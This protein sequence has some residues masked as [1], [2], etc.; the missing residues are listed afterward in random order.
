MKMNGGDGRSGRNG[1]KEKS[2]FAIRKS[3]SNGGRRTK[4]KGKKRETE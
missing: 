1:K 4:G 2:T 3:E